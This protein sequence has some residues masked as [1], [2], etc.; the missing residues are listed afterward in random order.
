[1]LPDLKA[2]RLVE[3]LRRML[4][5]RRFEEGLIKLARD[6]DIGHFHVYVGQ[7]ATG[8]LALGLLEEGDLSFTTHRNHGHLLARGVDPA[9]MYAEILGK[10]TGTNQ[11][12]GGTLHISSPDHGFPTTSAVT[13]GC[14][15]LATGAAFGFSRLGRAQISVC[16]MGRRR[17]GRGCLARVGQHCSDGGASQ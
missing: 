6:R 12:M 11:G 1:M 8:V 7:E 14:I 16:L 10:V 2:D 5:I 15:P 17:A 9:A 13:G 3:Y 4:V